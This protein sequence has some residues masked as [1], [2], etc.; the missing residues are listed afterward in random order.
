MGFSI[1]KDWPVTS[2]FFLMDGL[3]LLAL[4]AIFRRFPNHTAPNTMAF[5]INFMHSH[6]VTENMEEKRSSEIHFKCHQW[7]WCGR[8]LTMFS[9]QNVAVVIPMELSKMI[10]MAVQMRQ[11]SVNV[12]QD[13]LALDVTDVRSTIRTEEL[14][15]NLSVTVSGESNSKR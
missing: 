11:I 4:K 14:T 1:N 10:Q 8:S 5:E 6:W 15:V 9:K 2:H 13:T 7:C 3:L 12:R